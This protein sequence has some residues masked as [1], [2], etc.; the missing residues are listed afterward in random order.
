MRCSFVCG[1]LRRERPAPGLGVGLPHA[2]IDARFRNEHCVAARLHHATAVE[3]DNLSSTGDGGQAVGYD[4][5]RFATGQMRKSLLHAVLIVGVGKG[6]GLVQH[7]D[8][9]ILQE[10]ACHA[11]ALRLAPGKIDAAAANECIVSLRQTLDKLITTSCTGGLLH[12][13]PRSAGRPTAM[14]A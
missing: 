10:S 6:R 13:G 14:L 2:A 12:L 11:N 5:D 4:D 1:R 9:G 7:E 8:G 3:H